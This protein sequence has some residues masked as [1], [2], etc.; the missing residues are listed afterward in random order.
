MMN[1]VAIHT[2]VTTIQNAE[3][4]LGDIHAFVKKDYIQL[5]LWGHQKSVQVSEQSA[6]KRNLDPCE[7]DVE[8]KL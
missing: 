2:P 1:V 3:T 8:K 4:R 6:D 5:E 7:I